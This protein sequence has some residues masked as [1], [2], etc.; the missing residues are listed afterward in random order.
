MAAVAKGPVAGM[1]AAAEKYPGLLADL[2]F[3][4]RKVTALVRAIAERLVPRPTAT[5]PSVRLTLLE[6]DLDRLLVGNDWP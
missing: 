3:Y 2:Q 6:F 1:L 5:A 4:R